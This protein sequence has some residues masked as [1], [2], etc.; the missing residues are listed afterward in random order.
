MPHDGYAP[1]N[2]CVRWGNGGYTWPSL[3]GG[4]IIETVLFI[5]V[6]KT[7]SGVRSRKLFPV[8]RSFGPLFMG[9][10]ALGAFKPSE[11]HR[12]WLENERRAGSGRNP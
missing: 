11:P 4:F 9:A 10:A 1:T 7:G 3:F 2:T 5:D 6:S 12:D 8:A